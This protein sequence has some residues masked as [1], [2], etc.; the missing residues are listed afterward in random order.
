MALSGPPS[1]TDS[2]DDNTV[3]ASLRIGIIFH[4]IRDGYAARA[5][6]FQSFLAMNRHVCSMST[7]VLLHIP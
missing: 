3:L 6:N 5:N 2:E 1:A 7:I 4:R